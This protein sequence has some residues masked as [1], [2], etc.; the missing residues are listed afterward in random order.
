MLIKYWDDVAAYF[1][2]MWEG[3]KAAFREGIFNGILH[4]LQ[5]FDP[6]PL[7]VNT[8]NGII[9]LLTGVDFGTIGSDWMLGLWNGIKG[10]WEDVTSWFSSA[11]D[12]LIGSMP[13]WVKERIGFGGASVG[14]ATPQGVAANQSVKANSSI[15][16]TSTIPEARVASSTALPTAA[17][18][19]EDG[20]RTGALHHTVELIVR[21]LP[22]GSSV[23]SRSDSANVTINARTGPLMAGAN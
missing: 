2:G 6:V 23:I 9:S 13:D 16:S 18:Q 11:V 19:Q 7:L 20:V 3:I 12:A 17:R 1:T 4:I 15:P 22:A 14:V 8:V 21:G 10:V 5:L